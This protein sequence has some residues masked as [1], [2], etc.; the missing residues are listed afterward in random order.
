MWHFFTNK[1]TI[2]FKNFLITTWNIFKKILFNIHKIIYEKTFPVQSTGL[3]LVYHT[4]L[5][6]LNYT[7]ALQIHTT[8]TYYKKRDTSWAKNKIK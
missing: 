6:Q 7:Y 1:I 8:H 4:Y 3:K 5:Y 2:F